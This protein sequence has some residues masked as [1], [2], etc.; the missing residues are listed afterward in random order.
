MKEVIEKA[1]KM[2]AKLKLGMMLSKNSVFYSTIC[3]NLKDSWDEKIPTA[4]TNGL[5]LKINP[6]WFSQLSPKK[7]LG[8]V[9]HEVSHVALMHPA[10]LG[11]RDHETFNKAADH[12]INLSL[13]E[14]GY[15]LPDNGLWDKRFKGMPTDDIY[16]I[17]IKEEPPSQDGGGG[18]DCD[19]SMGEEGESEQEAAA[20]ESEISQI[21]VS[22]LTQSKMQNED[23]GSIAGEAA[24]FLDKLLYPKL[25]WNVIL[26]N[27]MTAFAKEDYSYSRI[28]KRYMPEFML[29]GPYSE[30]TGEIS[31]A[32][33]TSGSVTDE[34]FQRIISEAHVI[35]EN[36][37]PSK[38]TIVDF[39][40]DIKAVHELDENK[41]LAEVKFT[42]RGGTNLQPV[43]DLF[44][45]KSPEVLIIFSDLWCDAITED[46]GYPVVWISVNNP[47]AVVHFGRLI[48]LTTE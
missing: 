4:S 6:T 47:K 34:E 26:Q 35:K 20:R 46:P 9:M 17:L 21:I 45:K 40:N 32:V 5:D 1:D 22:A 15:E 28:N 3:F 37:H 7:A 30:A 8:L 44:E 19:I 39:D 12:H 36:L 14:A 10:R 2:F 48:H 29:P 41:T 25:P 11:D 16:N 23:A 27:Y 31:I 38:F 33:D 24:V 42:G 43:F 18:Y 13:L